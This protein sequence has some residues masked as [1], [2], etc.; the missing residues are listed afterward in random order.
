MRNM[1]FLSRLIRANFA[2]GKIGHFVTKSKMLGVKLMSLYFAA[3]N[4]HPP[5]KNHTLLDS[6]YPLIPNLYISR[7]FLAHKKIIECPLNSSYIS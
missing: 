7:I 3:Y 2:W 6:L 4:P 5:K 1:N